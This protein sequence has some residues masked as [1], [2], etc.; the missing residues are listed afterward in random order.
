MPLYQ[1]LVI[2]VLTL[3]SLDPFVK[4]FYLFLVVP[5][6]LPEGVELNLRDV[7]RGNRTKG[8]ESTNHILKSRKEKIMMK[9]EGKNKV[10]TSKDPYL[11]EVD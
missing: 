7:L 11:H 3:F 10:V 8:K 2:L 4:G 5:H 9:H 1:S 6:L